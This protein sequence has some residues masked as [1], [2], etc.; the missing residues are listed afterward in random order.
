MTLLLR[1]RNYI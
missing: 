1:G